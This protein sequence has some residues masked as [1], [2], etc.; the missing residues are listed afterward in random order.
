MKPG[1]IHSAAQYGVLLCIN[2]EEYNSF[3]SFNDFA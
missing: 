2:D 3:L 1:V